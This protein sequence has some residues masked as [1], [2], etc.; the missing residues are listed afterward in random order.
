MD[1]SGLSSSLSFS[2]FHSLSVHCARISVICCNATVFVRL[3]HTIS[4]LS[5]LLVWDNMFV[6]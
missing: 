2:F 4:G 6:L 3:I 5:V 1:K